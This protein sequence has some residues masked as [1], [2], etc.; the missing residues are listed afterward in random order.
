LTFLTG[1]VQNSLLNST[2]PVGK[3]GKIKEKY[4]LPLGKVE[5]GKEKNTF[6]IG[7]VGIF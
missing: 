5:N 6:L 2:L 1:K 7:K 3:G 4:A